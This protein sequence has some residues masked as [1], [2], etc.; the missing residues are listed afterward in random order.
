MVE[1]DDIDEAREE[2]VDLRVA[3][4]Q[5]LAEGQAHHREDVG[6]VVADGPGQGDEGLEAAA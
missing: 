4:H 1:I 6:H 5:A 3:G 2:P